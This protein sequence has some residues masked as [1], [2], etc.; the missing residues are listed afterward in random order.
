[1]LYNSEKNRFEISAA[2][3]IF[4]AARGSS[5]VLTD[6]E[7]SAIEPVIPYGK[8]RE[9]VMDFSH[10]GIDFSLK[11]KCGEYSGDALS[12]CF[13]VSESTA[14][15][16]A[17]TEQLAR[18][19]AFIIAFM[20][21]STGDNLK[22]EADIRLSY[23]NAT[24]GSSAERRE[25]VS[26]DRLRV[27]F[28]KCIDAII[29]YASAER[30]RVAVRLPSM[31]TAKFPYSE[32]REGQNEFIRAVYRT[33]SRGGELFANAPTG[34]GKTVS[35]LYPAIR[36][37]GA[38]KARKVFYLTP[39]TTISKSV[40]D[41]LEQFERARVKIR[42]V[43]LPSKER[44]CEEGLLCRDGLTKCNNLDFAR[45]RKAVFALYNENITTVTV[46][47]IK[48]LAKTYTVC[49]HELALEYSELCDII[50]C[51]FNY[52]YDPEICL[53]RYFS[54]SGEYTFL[55]DEAHNLGERAREIYSAE[56]DT[57]GLLAL[58]TS[59]VI[60]EYS[61]AREAS[62]RL[63]KSF[64][65]LLFPLV[66]DEMREDSLGQRKGAYHTKTMP[67]ELYTLLDPTIDACELEL[68]RNLSAKDDQRSTRA[69][70]LK[71][72]VYALKKFKRCAEA[73]DEGFE[74]FITCEQGKTQ[75]ENS[76]QYERLSA[77]IFC[78]DT[79]NVLRQRSSLGKSSVYF[80][81]TLNPIDYFR[82]TLGGDRSSEVLRV[83]SPFVPE[84]LA[85]SVVDSVSTRYNEREDTLIEV[86]RFISA[87]MGPRVGNYMIFTPS[88]A[89]TKALYQTFVS[90]FPKIKAILQRPDM[91]HSEKQ[92]FLKNFGEKGERYL[93]AFCVTG[94]IYSEGIDLS[95]DKLIGAI[96][97]GISMPTPSMEREAIAAYYDEKLEAGKLYSYIYPGLNKVLQA[98]GRVI[99]SEDDRGIIVLIDDRFR[100]PL[101][102]EAA[103]SLWQNMTYYSRAADLNEDIKS[104]WSS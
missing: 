33:I 69:R 34:T 10:G 60:S 27:F 6:G 74:L 55:V 85:V 30:E 57:L 99:R 61:E 100:D 94:G 9:I 35:A 26:A 101:Y 4:T 86:C 42:A 68:K 89:Y 78:L 63:A 56:L 98:A 1:M 82:D 80:S 13:S 59:P 87:S 38:E 50:V 20:L 37:L 41:C 44:C 31:K 43:V 16:K 65:R 32:M 3:L 64:R 58:C 77:K 39:K 54:K 2:E 8:G 83:T 11:A 96:I 67:D 21:M 95:G 92:E 14:R 73:F 91:T 18:G 24:S 51:D 102:R 90:K 45:I 25:V 5:S 12:L 40:K 47:D 93:A 62:E 17:S 52:L 76:E 22:N 46:S 81:G 103:P 19:Q 7:I 66:K 104:F 97:V 36:A 28:D 72:Y 79:G 84:Q 15:L 70:L 48:R 23:Q 29:P 53:K 88:Y 49:P 75:F 71:D